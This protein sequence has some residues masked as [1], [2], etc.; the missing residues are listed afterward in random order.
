MTIEPNRE[1]HL[2]MRWRTI[3]RSRVISVV[4]EREEQVFLVLSL[5]IGA[6][7]GLTVVAF[8]ALTERLGMRL[9]PVGSPGWRRVIIPV[10]GALAIGYLLYRYFPNARGSGVPEAKAALYAREGNISLRTVLGK[11]ACTAATLASGI[12]LGREGPSVQVSAGIA[13]VLGRWLG[14]SREKVK[15][16]IPVGAAAGIAAAFNTPMAAVLFALEEVVGDLHAPVLGSVVLASATS[17]V[18]LRLLLGNNPLFHVPQYEL[19]HPLEFGIYAV[20]GI[21]GGFLSVAFTRLLLGMRKRFLLL[22]RST[23]WWQP[24]AGGLLVGVMGWFVPQ[25]LGV[26]YSYVGSA[27]DGMMTLKLMLLLVVLKLFAVTVSYASGNAG[28]IFGPSLFLGAM[29]GGAVGT[30]AHHLLPIYTAAPGAY[31]LVGMGALFAG[32]VRAPMT[33][34]LMIFETTRDYSV[35]VPLMIANLASLFISTR[36]QKLPIYQALARQD[37]IHLPSLKTRE[38]LRGRIVFQVRRTSME[39]L[40]SQMS[41]QNA[42]E[43]TQASQFRSWLVEDEGSIVGVLSRTTLETA[44]TNGKGEQTLMSLFDALDFPHVHADHPLHL[45]L[46][47]MSKAHID[48]LPVVNRADIHKL[49][50]IIT[51]RDVLDSY[52]VDS[53]GSA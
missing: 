13:S 15:A 11:F 4:Q 45:A 14:L 34:V 53:T 21:V 37:G 8:I 5:L 31:A 18:V 33:S 39:I 48:I 7:A 36:F 38:E 6:L 9:Y 46:E 25:V 26:G 43:R 23:R 19:V 42:V 24:V 50:G 16:L 22:P 28:G 1:K 2:G 41:V 44:V 51:L 27:L 47:R 20:L 3:L 30:V 29:L 40:P 32:I 12:P 17:W 49:E 35:I 10:V 52:G